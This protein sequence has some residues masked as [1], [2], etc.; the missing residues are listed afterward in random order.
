M[1]AEEPLFL[2]V[3]FLSSTGTEKGVPPP[4]PPAGGTGTFELVVATCGGGG[5]VGER[6]VVLSITP[7]SRRSRSSYTT[8]PCPLEILRAALLRSWRS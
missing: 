2:L 1:C 4:L 6:A 8:S 3:L 7:A 5:A